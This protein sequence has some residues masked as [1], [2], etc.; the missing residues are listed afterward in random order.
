[1]AFISRIPGPPASVAEEI[2]AF[3]A[4]CA[5]ESRLPKRQA[6]RLA[7]I[8]EAAETA[9][10]RGLIHARRLRSAEL[11]PEAHVAGLRLGLAA[12]SAQDVAAGAHSLAAKRST[13]QFGFALGVYARGMATEALLVEETA[14][15]A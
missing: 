7:V 1:M 14:R 6:L 5:A 10:R 11:E 9:R 4:L 15:A 13:P 12:R 2:A 3:G 8:V